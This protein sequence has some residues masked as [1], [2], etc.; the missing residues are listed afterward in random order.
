MRA[1]VTGASSG[2]GRAIATRLAADG[3]DLIVTARR[4]ERLLALKQELDADVEIVPAD[5]S[6]EE[7]CFALFDRV[8]DQPFDILI[9]NAG[10]GVFG[11]FQKTDLTREL[12]MLR[13]N[14]TA[15]HILMKLCLEKFAGQDRGYILN[16]ASSAAFLP[17]PLFSGYYASK[18]YVLRLSQAV[19]EE[20]RREKSNV[21]IGAFCPGPIATEFGQAADVKKGFTGVPL[22][23]AADYA[24]RM[25]YKRKAVII[26]GATMKLARVLDKILP[27][28]VLARAAYNLQKTKFGG[29]V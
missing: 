6:R 2:I 26:P 25:M 4:E 3:H 14:I 27:D 5:L 11:A 8:K 21:Y 23:C 17:G 12:G 15:M 9:N 10:L 7:E 28:G 16:V 18:A 24:V 13:V 20:L 19:R 1:L 22:S 29:S